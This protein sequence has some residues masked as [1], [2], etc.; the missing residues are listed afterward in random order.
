MKILL[1]TGKENVNRKRKER[2]FLLEMILKNHYMLYKWFKIVETSLKMWFSKCKRKK[3]KEHNDG[4]I[5]ISC[6][7]VFISM[8]L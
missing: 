2:E 8:H 1:K 6:W 3:E 5:M 4:M 7:K